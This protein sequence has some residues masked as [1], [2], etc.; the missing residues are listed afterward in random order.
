MACN[1]G[2]VQPASGTSQRRI[3]DVLADKDAASRSILRSSAATSTM[4][5]WPLQLQ[6]MLTSNMSSSSSSGGQSFTGV[7]ASV[8]VSAWVQ[9]VG[10]SSFW[11]GQAWNRANATSDGT[12][13]DSA[14]CNAN[15]KCMAAVHLLASLA[16]D[17]AAISADEADVRREATRVSRMLAAV[18]APPSLASYVVLEGV[19]I[20]TLPDEALASLVPTPTPTPAS[21]KSAFPAY[22]AALIVIVCLAA[23][24]TLLFVTRAR[25]LPRS[26]G[27]RRVSRKSV[28]SASAPRQYDHSQAQAHVNTS[29]DGAGSSTT[30][31]VMQQAGG[32]GSVSNSEPTPPHRLLAAHMPSAFNSRRMMSSSR[33]SHPATEVGV[34]L[35]TTFSPVAALQHQ[36]QFGASIDVVNPLAVCVVHATHDGI[37]HPDPASY[38]TPCTCLGGVMACVRVRACACVQVH[39]TSS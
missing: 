34:E 19:A 20:S 33:R 6:V 7:N 13:G 1:A 11:M 21:S 8:I 37:V 15:S 31:V 27:P 29:G 35:K 4:P 25:W 36:P 18:A 17:I 32:R 26:A 16:T 39:N 5:A 12:S 28:S 14:W 23:L 24:G 22:A 38:H 9:Q 30:V 10:S 3:M 2:A